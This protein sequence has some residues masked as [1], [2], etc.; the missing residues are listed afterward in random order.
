MENNVQL[1][2]EQVTDV[3]EVKKEKAKAAKLFGLPCD[4]FDEEE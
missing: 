1:T 2:T 4:I 3:D